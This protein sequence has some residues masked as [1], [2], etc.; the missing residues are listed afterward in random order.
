VVT[1]D[2]FVVG[3]ALDCDLVLDDPLVSRQ[4]AAFVRHGGRL[5]VEDCGSRNGVL[6]NGARIE[7][8]VAVGDGDRITIGAHAFVLA[9]PEIDRERR[10]TLEQPSQSGQYARPPITVRPPAPALEE[11]TRSISIF[12]MLIAT[13]RRALDID[14]DLTAESAAQNLL[15]SVRA[16]L[17]RSRT[18][19]D[20]VMDAIVDI[21]LEL[22]VRARSARW[23]ERLFELHGGARRVLDADTIDRIHRVV[24]EQGFTVSGAIAGYLDRIRA[25]GTELGEDE[26]RRI[27]RLGQIA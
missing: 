21:F 24:I 25:G 10:P 27:L 3:R 18:L 1:G 17:L 22:A 8:L 7:G 9:A 26:R 13:S 14:D 19:D 15:V 5:L 11:V 12:G 16:E 20:Y 4:H 23:V 2:R 6:V